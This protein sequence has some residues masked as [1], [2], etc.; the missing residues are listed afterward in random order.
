MARP[1]APL[2]PRLLTPEEAALY[3][4]YRSTAVLAR[5]PVQPLQIAE[6][7]KTASPRYDRCALDAWLDRKSG[8]VAAPAEI[9]GAAEL[10]AGTE[11]EAWRERKRARRG[12]AP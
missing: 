1:L 10:T 6:D 2:Q 3:L 12:Q 7:G 4:G 8:L 5:V 9:G 11:L